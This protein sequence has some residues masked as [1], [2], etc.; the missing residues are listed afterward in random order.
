MS[1]KWK[2][3]EGYEDRYEVS[4]HGNIRSIMF[5][6]NIVSKARI[7]EKSQTINKERR[8]YVDLEKNGHRKNCLVHRLVAKAFIPNPLN[9]PEVNHIDGNPTNNNVSN[10][11][12]CTK[13]QNLKHAY[14]NNLSKLRAYNEKNKKPIRRSDGKIYDSSYSAAHDLSVSVCSIRDVLKKRINSCKGYT[15]EYL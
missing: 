14:D 7:K 11:E 15:F 12:W 10:L 13:K 4:D 5:V 2:A 3:I 8:C 1:E 9:L 6:N